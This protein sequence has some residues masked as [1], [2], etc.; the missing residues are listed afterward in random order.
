MQFYKS[1]KSIKGCGASFSFNSK[2]EALFIS[3]IKQSGYDEARHI[4]Q[5]QGAKVVVKSGITEIGAL[6]DVLNRNVPYSTVH[7]T[8]DSKVQI[9]FEPYIIGEGDA[10]VQKGYGLKIKKDEES[11]LMPFNFS[12]AQVLKE[13]FSFVLRHI[14][15]A[16]YA[17]AKKAYKEKV[18]KQDKPIAVPKTEETEE[19]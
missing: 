2:D 13:Y 11:F 4:G 16:Q 7:T 10:K 12:E 14:F 9:W 6:L 15:S 19:I 1:N 3:L 17:E 5:F 8:K 18:E